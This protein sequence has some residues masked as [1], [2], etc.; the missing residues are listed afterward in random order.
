[1][2]EQGLFRAGERLPSIRTLSNR[3]H[4]G[5]NTVKQAY[6]VLENARVV[7][8]RVRSGF[9]V[10]SKPLG[11]ESGRPKSN[12]VPSIVDLSNERAVAI[13]SMS[14]ERLL[15]LGQGSPNP[16]LLPT[17]KLHCMLASQS[18]RFPAA[19]ASYA[20]P[21]GIHRLRVQ[22]AKRSL[23]YGCALSADDITV[24]SGCVEAVTLALQATCRVGNT[25]AVE[26][27]VYYTFLNAMRLLG[28]KILE[29]PAAP[30]GGV[31]LDVLRYALL[32]N[33]VHACL[34]I[35]NFNNPL[36]SLM[37]PEKKREIVH[38][39]GKL[40]IP[41]IEDDVYGDLGFGSNR[42][43][44]FKTYDEKGMVLLCSSFSKTLAPGYRV[45]W[46][47]AGRFQEKVRE[48]KSLFSVATA[49]PTQLAV[50]EFLANGAYDRHLRTICECVANSAAKVRSAIYRTFPRGTQTTTPAGGYVLWVELPQGLDT[51][52]LAEKAARNAIGIAPGRLFSLGGGFS[53][54][55]RINHS[56][57]S[58][59]V[60]HALG[61]LG[62]LVGSVV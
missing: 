58:E 1:M 17:A 11:H 43:P 2:I 50:A 59:E 22:I 14:D 48:L 34:L 57:W 35:S 5:I 25:V 15:P 62:A 19:S 10:S 52:H 12:L 41:L 4:V 55:L 37:H 8:G 33:P 60:G 38:T 39:L 40:A 7:E 24:T 9:Y 6:V 42:P 54:C 46:I 18:R 27:P 26:S 28:L 21:N 13:R 61:T 53:N 51:S 56:Y 29:I 20:D 31:S 47:A 36:G 30:E 16:E 49:T 44:V 23:D 3:L 32:K 45:G